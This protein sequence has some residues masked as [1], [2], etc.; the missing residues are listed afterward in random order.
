MEPLGIA[1][2][3]LSIMQLTEK[4][5]KVTEKTQSRAEFRAVESLA[6]LLSAID[7]EKQKLQDN[8]FSSGVASL[9]T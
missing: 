4:I 5:L 6:E 1:S 8:K 9:L 3:A 2:S 7:N